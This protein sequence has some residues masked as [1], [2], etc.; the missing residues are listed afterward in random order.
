MTE[1]KSAQIIHLFGQGNTAAG[2]DV[3]SIKKPRVVKLSIAGSHNVGVVGDH[4][5]V[6]VLTVQKP[7]AVRRVI[8]R[9][10]EHITQAQGVE[11]HALKDEWAALHSAIKKK[12][13]SHGAAWKDINKAGGANTY[14]EIRKDRFADAVAFVKKEMAILRNMKSA[15]RKD[16]GWR[17]KK[18]GAIKA[19]CKNQFGRVDV[20][21]PY[22]KKNF[23]AVS[24]VDLATD[25]LQQTYA[26]VMAK[27]TAPGGQ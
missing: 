8:Q 22:I 14:R 16:D 20:Y 3:V 17:T 5:Q 21:K 19:R 23:G 18:I 11:L 26:Y 12:P 7:P 27:K 25:E 24:L 15:P 1:K 9:T 2:R 4:N 13:F 10:D 6:N